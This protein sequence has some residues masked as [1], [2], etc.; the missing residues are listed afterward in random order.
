[1]PRG[2]GERGLVDIAARKKR[3]GSGLMTV[4]ALPPRNAESETKR[5][6]LASRQKRQ[7]PNIYTNTHVI[8]AAMETG[9]IV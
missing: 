9:D 4:S 1:M 7:C 2:A 6:K 5:D 8:F 3:V